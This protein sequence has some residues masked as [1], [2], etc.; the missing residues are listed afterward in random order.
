MP[1]DL[2]N[3][4]SIGEGSS[5]LIQ[6]IS[7]YNHLTALSDTYKIRSCPQ[8]GA[9]AMKKDLPTQLEV[10]Q[11][12][13][14]HQNSANSREDNLTDLDLPFFERRSP[15]QSWRRIP[16]LRSGIASLPDTGGTKKLPSQLEVF[17]AC[18]AAGA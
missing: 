15:L 10:F 13:F 14:I 12:C 3:S 6:A 16:Q 4:P 18:F 9:E 2:C 7:L 1:A 5:S 8:E 11:T 17:R